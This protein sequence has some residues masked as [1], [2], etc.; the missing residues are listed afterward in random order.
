MRLP[1][2]HG[3]IRRRILVNFRVDPEIIQRLLPAPFRPKLVGGAAL[4]GICLI[5][6]E[7][8]RPPGVPRVLGLSSENAAHRVAVVW[9]TAEGEPQE[10]VYIPRRDSGS[11]FNTLVGDRIFPGKHHRAT[12]DVREEGEAIEIAMRSH[13]G[14]V[15][16]DL[17]GRRGTRL[18]PTSR[19]ASIAEASAFFSKGSLGYSETAAGD[20][21]DG[22]HLVT[23]GWRVEALDVEHV[24]SSFFSSAARFPPGSVAFD[25]A[26]S[27]RNVEHEWHLAPR[28]A[29]SNAELAPYGRGLAGRE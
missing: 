9:T 11:A 1:A 20:R 18:A 24:H 22:L 4:A 21:L 8:L 3:V 25:C 29:R 16:V 15:A 5:R 14:E 27:M 13:D 10:G 12:F 6:L 23:R 26:L 28:I 7:Q 17:R 2:L 19:F